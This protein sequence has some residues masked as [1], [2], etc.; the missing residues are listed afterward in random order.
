MIESKQNDTQ[1]TITWTIEDI[2]DRGE[3][4]DIFI[5]DSM[6]KEILVNIK[7]QHDASIGINWDVIDSHINKYK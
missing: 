7:H 6:A 1:I 2:K 3:Y 5:N 4:Q